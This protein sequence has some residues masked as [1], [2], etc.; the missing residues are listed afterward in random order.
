MYNIT[1]QQ[2][3][4]FLTVGRYLNMSRAAESLYISQPTLSKALQR[5]ESGIGF[6]V[7]NRNNKGV[8]LTPQGE[9]LLGALES[10]YNN[11]EKA[12][13]AAKEM[14]LEKKKVLRIVAPSSYDAVEDYSRLKQ[15]VQ[16]F[17]DKYPDVDVVKQLFDFRELQRQFEFGETDIAFTH[18]FA[19]KKDENVRWK[20]ISE[21]KMHLAMSRNHPLAAYDTLQPDLLSEQTF[22]IVAQQDETASKE[23][24]VK[25]CNKIGVTPRR[26]ELLDNFPT[27][28]NVLRETHGVSIC[29]RFSLIG[30]KDDIK[31]LPLELGEETAYIVVAW[32]QDRLSRQAQNFIKMLPD[33]PAQPQDSST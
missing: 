3:E 1:F 17:T 23:R 19:L 32:H 26:I 31:Y 10:L 11:M 2:I 13:T 21:Y 22:Y 24:L 30:P 6:A 15:Y 12:I 7:F 16:S 9:Y 4:A 18:S 20:Y 14:T 27:L 33:N 28:M 5:F 25:L 29:A 8:S